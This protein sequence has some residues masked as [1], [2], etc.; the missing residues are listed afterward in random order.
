M[1][2]RSWVAMWRGLLPSHDTGNAGIWPGIAYLGDMRRFAITAPLVALF[3]IAPFAA[4]AGIE[5]FVGSYAGQAE[6]MADGETV[7]R[8]MSTTIEETREGFAITWTSG[9]YKPDGRI[10]EKTYEIEFTPSERDNIYQAAMKA[11][12]FGKAVPLDPLA[13]EPFVWARLEG[14]TF[15][16][17]S[18]FINEAGEYEIQEFHRTLV[19]AGL[20]LVFLRVRNG[21]P[22]REIRTVLV[23]QN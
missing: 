6:F 14:N 4:L 13:G 17:Y 5:R 10:K 16:V 3:L 18:L 21:Q 11:N 23:R 2:V 9:T 22:E 15:S 12:L 7:R 8:D 19:E 20:D 1:N